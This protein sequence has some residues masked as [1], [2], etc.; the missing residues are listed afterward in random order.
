MAKGLKVE[1]K[2]IH[3]FEGADKM[4]HNAV[5]DAMDVIRMDLVRTSSGLAP[6]DKGHLENSYT[7]KTKNVPSKKAEFEVSFSAFNDGFNYAEWTH[8]ADYNLGVKSQAKRPA[9]SR[10]SN[11]SFTVGK[12]Y[13]LKVAEACQEG[14][15]KFIHDSIQK[16]LDSKLK[17]NKG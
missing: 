11:T 14:W 5:E 12:G 2:G 4:V 7:Q 1:I 10:F 13:L 6:L 8:N 9:R 15:Q 3:A 17:N 16:N